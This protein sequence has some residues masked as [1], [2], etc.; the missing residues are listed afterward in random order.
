MSPFFHHKFNVLYFSSNGHPLNFGE[1]DIYKSHLV[2]GHWR[3]PKSIGP[4]VNGKGEEFY[5]T[6]DSDS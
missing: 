6:I 4:L 1:F 2:N 3:E 5:F